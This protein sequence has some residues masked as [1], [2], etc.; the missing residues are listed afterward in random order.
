MTNRTVEYMVIVILTDYV[1]L[2]VSGFVLISCYEL[3]RVCVVTHDNTR[4]SITVNRYFRF[5]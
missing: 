4:M 3:R 2:V 5:D 1:F